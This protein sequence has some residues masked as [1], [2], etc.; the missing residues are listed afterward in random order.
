[1]FRNRSPHHDATSTSSD[2][3][4]NGD[5]SIQNGGLGDIQALNTYAVDLIAQEE[6]FEE[7][8]DV[9]KHAIHELS[10]GT[11]VIDPTPLSPAFPPVVNELPP[12]QLHQQP[13]QNEGERQAP[14]IKFNHQS[15]LQQQGPMTQ[16]HARSNG[17]TRSSVGLYPARTEDSCQ[18]NV[19]F[20]DP[21]STYYEAECDAAVLDRRSVASLESHNP[22]HTQLLEQ[23]CNCFVKRPCMFEC[24]LCCNQYQGPG[25][26]SPKVATIS[27]DKSSNNGTRPANG[28]QENDDHNQQEH[29]CCSFGSCISPQK[30]CVVATACLFNLALCHHMQWNEQRLML[31]GHPHP[32]TDLED[33]DELLQ[34]PQESD[35]DEGHDHQQNQ[36]PNRIVNADQNLH[37]LVR[38]LEIYEQAFSAAFGG[39]CSALTSQAAGSITIVARSASTAATTTPT[40]LWLTE[41]SDW[42]ILMAVCSN[43]AH[44][45]MELSRLDQVHVWNTRLCH[46]LQYTA[47]RQHHTNPRPPP[48]RPHTAYNWDAVVVS[49]EPMTTTSNRHHDANTPSISLSSSSPQYYIQ[50]TGTSS[51]DRGGGRYHQP[52]GSINHQAS[53]PLPEQSY[54]DQ[55]F[56]THE[57]R[58]FMWHC[59]LRNR[60]SGTGAPVA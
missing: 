22:Q 17:S 15:S 23:G 59:V 1:M 43:A 49:P 7:A 48:P 30:Y 54:Y 3:D 45:A 46:A 14:M 55:R 29:A 5:L 24:T 19:Y 31:Q 52:D 50:N 27:D 18:L 60:I 6:D 37:H 34:Q 44:C 20:T 9:L 39:S 8:S 47:R 13:R 40:L 51:T 58:S 41:L 2:D 25:L 36:A 10:T 56:A 42:K 16:S 28:A 11:V 35:E 53:P 32:N 21:D 33:E 4:D 57:F 26:P 38:A 12:Q